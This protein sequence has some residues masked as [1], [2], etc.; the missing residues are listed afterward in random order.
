[1]LDQSYGKIFSVA[2][3]LMFGTL[4]QS[5]VGVTDGIMVSSLGTVAF[6]AVGNGGLM[7]ISMFMLCKGIGDGAQIIIA[8]KYGEGNIDQIGSIL[9]GAQFTALIF[10]IVIFVFF[11][12][13][14]PAII[15]AICESPEIAESMT[16]FIQYRSWGI[17]FA[18]VH[19]ATA[20]LFIGLGKTNIYMISAVILAVSNIILDY[21][22]IFGE[23]GLPQ[24]GV[25][26]AAL[27]SS[28]SE[29][30]ACFFLLAY[31]LLS[32]KFKEFNCS[33]RHKINGSEILKLVKLSYPLMLQGIL[34][35]STW[36]VFFMM[37]EQLGPEKLEASHNIRYMYFIAFVPIFGFGATTRTFVSNLVGQNKRE[38]IVKTQWRIA[39]LS[40][41]TMFAVFHGSIFYPELMIEMINHNPNISP[42]VMADS[43]SIL[44]FVCWSIFLFSLIVV[45]YNA[46]AGLGKTK[47]ALLIEVSAIITYL[48]ASY[49][50]IVLWKWDIVMVWSVEYIYFVTMGILSLGMLRYFKN[51]PV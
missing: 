21:G 5:V 26:G 2:L 42:E 15:S 38:L 34:A 1:M 9:F 23:L 13:C 48:I 20:A 36:L 28:I 47:A 43:V 46:V 35:L 17:V 18:C 44:Q 29:F 27:A 6:D 30:I 11:L 40:L 22:L 16:G 7:Y 32:P 4:I 24:M 51:R 8:R 12:A 19:V 3:P 49:I 31:A 14:G 10:G 37:I 45:P 50:F 25:R 39:L 33:L 41:I